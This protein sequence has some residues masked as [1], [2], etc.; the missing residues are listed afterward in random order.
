MAMSFKIVFWHLDHWKGKY[1][2][3]GDGERYEECS[4][5]PDQDRGLLESNVTCRHTIIGRN[6]TIRVRDVSDCNK[7]C[8]QNRIR[9]ILCEIMIFG[10]EYEGKKTDHTVEKIVWSCLL[11]VWECTLPFI[12]DNLQRFLFLFFTLWRYTYVRSN[13]IINFN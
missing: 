8:R 1:I 12:L 5:F 6:V 11:N 2:S 7:Q 10:Y 13:W 3:V 4:D 9:L